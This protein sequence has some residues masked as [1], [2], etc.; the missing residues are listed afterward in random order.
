MI[1]PVPS[2]FQGIQFQGDSVADE[3]KAIALP[4]ICEKLLEEMG[5]AEG[6]EI[7][8]ST[9]DGSRLVAAVLKAIEQD[10][11]EAFNELASYVFTAENIVHKILHKMVKTALQSNI[12][13]AKA[14]AIA[15]IEEVGLTEVLQSPGAWV[16][17]EI[18]K[19]DK[20]FATKAKG[21]I[22]KEKIEGPAIIA[23]TDPKDSTEL[24]RRGHFKDDCKSKR[25]SAPAPAPT[26]APAPAP[27][28]RRRKA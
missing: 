22:K 28:R 5:S 21:I 10:N 14:M 1:A 16:V 2:V 20:K 12:K 27:A 8:G 17:A 23:I 15:A 19:S 7:I 4:A 13:E 9:P 11:E 18:A 3:L 24:Q 25:S 6:R 26:P